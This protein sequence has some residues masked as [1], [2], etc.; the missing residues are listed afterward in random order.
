MSDRVVTYAEVE[1]AFAG[2]EASSGE[3]QGE[4]DVDQGVIQYAIGTA[5]TELAEETDEQELDFAATGN[6]VASRVQSL[7][8]SAERG[9]KTLLVD[10]VEIPFEEGPA[11]RDPGW[12]KVGWHILFGPKPHPLP[13]PP[14][15]PADLPEGRLAIVGDWGTGRYGAPVIAKTLESDANV[16]MMLHLGDVYYSG[17]RKEV[18]KRFLAHWPRRPDAVHRA[19]NGN[20]EMYSGGYGYFEKIL[21]AFGQ[22]SSYFAYQTPQWLLLF[23]DTAYVDHDLGE[24]QVAWIESVIAAAPRKK[25]VLFSHH[26]L[27]T[28]FGKKQGVKLRAK[29]EPVLRNPNLKAWYWGHEHRCIRYGQGGDYRFLARCVGHGGIPTRRR[30]D[31]YQVATSRNGYEWRSGE[32]SDTPPF[33]VLDG[34]NPHVEEVG[35]KYSP[36]GYATLE[37]AGDKLIERYHVAT[38]EEVC[39]A[40]TIS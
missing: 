25:I 34:P 39:D 11:G 40:G 28:H 10:D 30:Y 14:P 2:L 19:L 9:A 17:T 29:L 37:F 4:S 3:L 20:H 23:L 32:G 16:G 21:P 15:E 33:L 35:E 7:L 18:A 5:L 1:R 8:G 38:G 27:F 36:N 13:P 22:S 24:K 6:G 31:E 12:L 26:H